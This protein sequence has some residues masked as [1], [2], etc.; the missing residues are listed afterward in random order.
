MILHKLSGPLQVR[1]DESQATQLKSWLGYKPVVQ[2][3]HCVGALAQFTHFVVS[4]GLQILV[5]VS[6]YTPLF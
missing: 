3:V 4:H 1:Q 5:V 6:A 2:L